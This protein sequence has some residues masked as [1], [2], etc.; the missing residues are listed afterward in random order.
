MA[1]IVAQSAN[2][3]G[4]LFLLIPILLFGLTVGWF[5]VRAVRHDRDLAHQERLRAIEQGM[6]PASLE[7]ERK[8]HHN[9]FWIAFWIGAAVPVAAI[10]TVANTVMRLELPITLK[11]FMWGGIVCICP[12]WSSFG[13]RANALGASTP[14]GCQTT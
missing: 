1:M 11:W 9:V 7:S 5:V 14:V 8:Y 10:L 12:G 2:P 4:F 6:S 13:R 3:F